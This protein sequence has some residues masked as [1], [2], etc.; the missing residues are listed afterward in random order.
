MRGYLWQDLAGEV[1]EAFGELGAASVDDLSEAGISIYSAEGRER[2]WRQRELEEDRALGPRL[3]VQLRARRA[4]V[5]LEKRR[6]DAAMLTPAE[7]MRATR[8]RRAAEGKCV[9]CERRREPGSVRCRVHLVAQRENDRA[10]RERKTMKLPEKQAPITRKPAEPVH[11]DDGTGK[12]ACGAE[13]SGLMI[14]DVPL[15]VSCG[16]CQFTIDKKKK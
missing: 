16:W 11:L 8:A 9:G 13:C 6:A 10:Y 4:V 7:R 12:A 5:V 14:V 15:R 3:L 1:A 2:W